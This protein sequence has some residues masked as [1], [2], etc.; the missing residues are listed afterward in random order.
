MEIKQG[1]CKTLDFNFFLL[2]SPP[3]LYLISNWGQHFSHWNLI[4][5]GLSPWGSTKAAAPVHT[6]VFPYQNNN[7]FVE[8]I[9]LKKL[10]SAYYK[11]RVIK[12]VFKVSSHWPKMVRM[13]SEAAPSCQQSSWPIQVLATE[14][15]TAATTPTTTTGKTLAAKTVART[16]EARR[17]EVL[18][19]PL[20]RQKPIFVFFGGAEATPNCEIEIEFSRWP[21]VGDVAGAWLHRFHLQQRN[22]L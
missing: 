1:P 8:K 17:S 3:P 21:Q 18:S 14:L 19:I 7:P 6:K 16:A 5:V 11:L 12:S 22:S 2:I 10:F 9:N 20:F 4:R 15:R 13:K